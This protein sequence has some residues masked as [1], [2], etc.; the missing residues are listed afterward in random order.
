[1]VATSKWRSLLLMFTGAC[2][3]HLVLSQAPVRNFTI[4]YD[5]NTFLKDGKPFRYVSGSI[6]YS[7]VPQD[8]WLD[9]LLKM[10][11][12]GLN[13][14]Q[15]YIPWNIHQTSKASVYDFTGQ[16]DFV[17]FITL[18]HGVGLLVI[19]RP[20]PF[21]C[22]EWDFGGLPAWILKENPKTVF[23]SMDSTYIHYVDQWFDVLMPKV[24]PLLYV[25]GGPI[26]TIQ[27]ENEYGSYFACDHTYT[28][29]LRDKVISHLGKDVVLFTT[30]NAIDPFIKCGK[31][32]GVY[33]T[34]DFGVTEYEKPTDK[35]KHQR[36]F[37]PKG[38]LVNSEY[39]TGWLDY[40]GSKHQVRSTANVAKDLDEL[41]SYG[42]NVN[43]Y[44]FEG[45]T[46]FGYWNGANYFVFPL[47][48]PVPTSYDYDAPLTEAG[49]ITPKYH[50][51]R[52]VISKY[53]TLPDIP[54]PTSSQKAK[55]GTV[56]MKFVG[57]VQDLLP[58]LSPTGGV[59]STHPLTMEAIGQNQG[60]ALYRHVLKKDHNINTVL[61]V[62]GVRDRGYVML[63]NTSIGIVVRE[64]DPFLRIS[65]KK[66]QVLDILVEN[67]GHINVGRALTE[68]L[69]GIIQDVT[70][71]GEVLQDWVIFPILP[72]NIDTTTLA[73]WKGSTSVPDTRVPSIYVGQLTISGDPQDTYLDM[74]GWSKGQALLEGEINLGRYWPTAGPQVR[75]YVPRP[76]LHGNSRLNTLV[77]LELEKAPCES[78]SPCSVSF[79]DQPL[80]NG[81]TT[82]FSRSHQP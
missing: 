12:A 77:M 73:Q 45:G 11:A 22:A 8:Y 31:I 26:I 14:I 63:D 32:P 64:K 6:H 19:L 65:G 27:I 41:L 4:D 81:T 74:T 24:K 15:V 7:R 56:P 61:Q 60:F 1:M 42:A 72:E 29:H 79:V 62:S 18:A 49:D 80:I 16:Q 71:G 67:Q 3:C 25:N 76:Y 10:Y 57:T 2:C 40:W 47:F 82:T 59:I 39:Y 50:T 43:M 13:A 46:N 21:I 9:R 66:G 68:N 44:M 34:I 35:F 23:R 70:L 75:M 30:D 17:Q 37:E 36:K 54:I 5:K 53:N 78:S 33:S 55:Y 51:L 58:Q 20:G 48:E 38:P 52:Q 28:E 69:K